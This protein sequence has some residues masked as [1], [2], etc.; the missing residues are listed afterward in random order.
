M[1]KFFGEPLKIINS[2]QSGKPLFRFDTK[3]EFIT[4]DPEIINRAMGFFDYIPMK[5]EEAGERVEKTFYTPPLTI[6]TKEMTDEEVRAK[7]KELGIKSWHTK[8]I[9]NLL[10]E[11]KEDN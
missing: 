1:I 10:I 7:A 8:K 11:M 9:E 4:D 2:K 6:T 5:A 3:G